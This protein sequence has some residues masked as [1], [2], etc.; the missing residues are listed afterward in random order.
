MATITTYGTISHRVGKYVERTT[1]ARAKDH[2]LLGSFAA[3]FTLPK[4]ESDTV[5]WSR[6]EKLAYV[7]TPLIEG[8]TP[9]PTP[10]TRTDIT[11][12]LEQF[13]A[14]VRISDK[15]QDNCD[16]PV[17]NEATELLGMQ[18]GM[19]VDMYRFGKFKAGT[20]V[21]YSGTVSTR[22]TVDAKIAVK[23]LH[24]IARWFRSVGGDNLT[25]LTEAGTKINTV[26]VAPAYYAVCHP[27]CIYDIENLTGFTRVKD[28]ASQ[29]GV[30]DTEFGS[31]SCFRFVWS[32]NIEPWEAGGAAV[33]ATGMKANDATNIDVYPILFFAKNA[34]G[35]VGL[36]GPNAISTYITTPGGQGDELHQKASAAWK[37]MTGA[38]ILNELWLARL[39]TGVTADASI[40]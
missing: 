1:L 13:G 3:P 5:Q 6:Y 17:I 23:D 25:E 9:T 32:L 2:N 16:D 29:K 11:C 26:S 30:K 14:L 28:Y 18:A 15:V 34:C 12:Q 40:T 7:S 39:E 37:C 24:K 31:F 33:G 19:S 21:F 4:K 10:I 8:V 22:A 20:N 38:K 36:G 35:A 27:D